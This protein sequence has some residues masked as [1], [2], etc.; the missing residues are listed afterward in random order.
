ML[1]EIIATSVADAITAERN[2]ADRIELISGIR[3]GGVTPSFGLI[4]QVLAAVSIP[5]RVMVRP[6]AQSF[7]YDRYDAQTMLADIR[8]IRRLRPDGVVL[9]PLTPDGAVDRELLERLLE[10]CGGELRVTFHRAFDELADQVE[11]L[12]CLAAAYPAIDRVLTSGGRPSVLDSAAR[13]RELVAAAAGI[14]AADGTGIRVLAGSGLTV[15]TLDGFIG[16]TGVLE[17]HLGTG[18]RV[19]ADPLAPIDPARVRAAADIVARYR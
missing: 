8:M 16:A 13:I 19:G 7:H 17:V 1:L 6:H 14:A 10:A 3:E 11:A 4:E 2:G 15:E 5:V 9:G 18:V 12:R